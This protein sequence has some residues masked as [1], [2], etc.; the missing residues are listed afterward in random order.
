MAQGPVASEVEQTIQ[1]QHTLA[2]LAGRSPLDGRFQGWLKTDDWWA[3]KPLCCLLKGVVSSPEAIQW[4]PKHNTSFPFFKKIERKLSS[5]C[6][7]STNCERPEKL[8]G[9]RRPMWRPKILWFWIAL[10]GSFPFPISSFKR[11]H[12]AKKWNSSEPL[13]YFFHFL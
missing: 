4:L 3:Y 9:R 13:N 6:S 8:N 12:N 11:H 10:Q 2:E 7:L 5:N 1:R